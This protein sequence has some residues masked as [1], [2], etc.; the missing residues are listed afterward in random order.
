MKKQLTLVL[1][2]FIA[3]WTGA[4][5]AVTIPVTLTVMAG[6]GSVFVFDELQG[7]IEGDNFF[8]QGSVEGDQFRVDWTVQ[9]DLDPNTTWLLGVTNFAPVPLPFIIIANTITGVFVPPNRSSGSIGVTISDSDSTGASF[10]STGPNPVY[11]ALIDGAPYGAPTLLNWPY[12]LVAPVDGSATSVAASFGLP[13][14]ICPT[15]GIVATMGILNQFTLSGNAD[16][17][18]ITENI[19]VLHAVP[20]PATMTLI[21]LGLTGLVGRSLRRRAK[22]A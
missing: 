18:G 3:L 10:T 1:V 7:S 19:R 15:P 17:V 4:A 12:S 16:V 20:E 8:G 2:L 5:F 14:T 9:G 13:G 22:R 11:T 6:D 21:G